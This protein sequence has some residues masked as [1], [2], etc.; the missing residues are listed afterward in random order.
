MVQAQARPHHLSREPQGPA[1]LALP[2]W[3]SGTEPHDQSVDTGVSGG[4][5]RAPTVTLVGV[6]CL[7]RKEGAERGVFHHGPLV[8]QGFRE[9]LFPQK[10]S[11][12]LRRISD[13]IF[14]KIFV[15]FGCLG[16]FLLLLFRCNARRRQAIQVVNNEIVFLKYSFRDA[17]GC[18]LG[19]TIPI[20]Y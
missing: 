2:V 15:W 13:R 10:F 5:S 4:S 1:I 18:E 19:R 20:F 9:V 11:E 16:Y 17:E 7:L 6:S 3:E 12:L 14:C 8:F